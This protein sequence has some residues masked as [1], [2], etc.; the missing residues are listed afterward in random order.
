M[1]DAHR[2]NESALSEIHSL[3]EHPELNLVVAYRFWPQPP[4]L[5][6]LASILERHHP[7]VVLGP[8]DREAVSTEVTA[9]LGRPAPPT[10]VD[11]VL[12]L[13][14]GMP[15]LVHRVAGTMADRSHL[16]D[17]HAVM[18]QLGYDLDAMNPEV[19]ELLLA[20]TVGFDL[21]GRVPDSLEQG[22]ASIDDLVAEARAAGLIRSDGRLIPL[23]GKTLLHTTP[24]HHLRTLQRSLVN[25]LDDRGSTFVETARPL[26]RSGL[27]DVRIARSLERAG[28]DALATQPGLAATLYDEAL[29]A[30]A[31]KI[32]LAARRAQAFAATGDVDR[33][34]RILDKIF[35]HENPPDLTRAA[36]VAA[37]VWAQR[38]MLAR[39]ADIYRWLGPDRVG[40]SAALAGVALI[41][42]GDR[43]GAEDM[44]TAG[45]SAGSPTL[46][47][48]AATLAGQGI[49]ESIGEV[50]GDALPL[51]IRAS[52]VMSASGA[53]V[54]SPDYPAALAALVA[55]H[56]GELGVADSILDSALEHSQ[57]GEAARPRL[58]LLRAWTAMQA[59]RPDRA[60]AAIDE[61]TEN[62]SGLVQRD[63]L[64]LRAVE[65]GLARRADDAPALVLAWQRARECVLHAGVD[66]FSLMPLEEL[67][68][69]AARLRESVRIESHLAQAWELLRQL[70]NPPLWSVRLHWSAVQAAILTERPSDLAPHAAALVRAAQQNRLAFVLAA[71]GRAWLSVLAQSFDVATVESAA[72]G[73]ASVGLTWDGSRLAG[74]AAARTEER[75]D[76][77]RL[78]ACARDLHPGMAAPA[79]PAGGAVEPHAAARASVA[80]ARDK[81]GLS[82]REREIARLVLDGK[83]YREIGEAVFISPR[84][85]EHHIARI[86]SRLGASTRSEL[87][88]LLRVALD[89]PGD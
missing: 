17:M 21:S 78:L 32:T 55:L 29:A 37:A 26:A 20:L 48:V 50:A 75:K 7:S 85:A 1:D 60:R 19:R 6:R 49:R 31:E 28:D 8:L 89:G 88:T 33:T 73:L 13:T 39:G 82:A 66:L 53:M 4:A 77:A 67:V 14:A 84:T 10:L 52:D 68:V 2:L 69:A 44:F 54:P 79:T 38:G 63:E 56:S 87:L 24:V 3:V 23:I 5:L 80:G 9:A 47:T 22:D 43:A 51:L 58:L 36:D 72:R 59:D 15:W 46:S 12:Q 16:L 45:A 74:H 40:S 83:T 25:S 18:D 61:A 34:S 42:A 76:M 30:G 11:Q 35:A 65:V 64:L 62:S 81:T 70:G 71:A 57:C 27:K 41:G 86:R